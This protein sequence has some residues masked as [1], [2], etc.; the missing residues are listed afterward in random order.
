MSVQMSQVRGLP[1]VAATLTV[2]LGKASLQQGR[3][4]E[5]VVVVV[6]VVAV[7]VAVVWLAVRQTS[8]ASQD[9]LMTGYNDTHSGSLSSLAEFYLLAR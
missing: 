9:N 6:V 4:E 5:V 7:V 8:R 3:G 1:V 2:W